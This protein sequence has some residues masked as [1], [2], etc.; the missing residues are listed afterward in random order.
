MT[1]DE[2]F[3]ER[4]RLA[5]RNR[6]EHIGGGVASGAFSLVRSVTSGIKRLMTGVTGVVSQPLKGLQEGGAEGFFRG[7]GKGIVGVVTK[8]MYNRYNFRVGL[9][10]LATNMSDGLLC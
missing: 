8:P 7:L 4:R 2:K 5:S 10:D 1:M 3:Q 6:P 9:V